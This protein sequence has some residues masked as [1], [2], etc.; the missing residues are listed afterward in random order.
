MIRNLFDKVTPYAGNVRTVNVAVSFDNLPEHKE[1][2]VQA[3]SI[4][5][6]V[7]D[8]G[9]G[10]LLL[11]ADTGSEMTMPSASDRFSINQFWMQG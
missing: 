2:Y 7:S 5:R 10:D 1:N 9:T 6:M 11:V 8:L 3:A 4:F